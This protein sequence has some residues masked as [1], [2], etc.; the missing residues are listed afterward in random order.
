MSKKVGKL[1]LRYANALL[2][3]LKTV[4]G[5]A[6]KGGIQSNS[7]AEAIADTQAALA[8]IS[9]VWENSKEVR[10]HILNPMLS[11]T[12]RFRAVEA[13]T[14]E[15]KAPTQA[16]QFVRV[17]FDRNRIKL[18][19][20]IASAFASFADR[21]MGVVRVEVVTANSLQED[22]VRELEEMISNKVEGR[23]IF[24]W[25]VDSKILGGLV[26]RYQ[27]KSLDGSLGGSLDQLE[28]QLLASS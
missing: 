13:L 28:R 2:S 20:E 17:L 11:S 14:A 12:D 16:I 26:V 27:G 21:E 5:A 4:D 7:D 19:P 8:A 25:V 22:E 23:P 9:T 1:A 24:N 3:L 10:D 15:V 18:L 6:Q